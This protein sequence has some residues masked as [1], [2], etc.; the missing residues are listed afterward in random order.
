MAERGISPPILKLASACIPA[1]AMQPH[2]SQTGLPPN[3]HGVTRV[4]SEDVVAGE[5]DAG[6]TQPV[7]G[8]A[9]ST[10]PETEGNGQG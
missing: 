7:L 8:D 1:E 6:V 9:E 3:W 10:E 5:G 2:S 4:V